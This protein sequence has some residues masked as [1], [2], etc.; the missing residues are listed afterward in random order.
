MLYDQT[1][2]G[3]YYLDCS[4][5]AF[6][7]IDLPL[8]DACGNMGYLHRN[9]LHVCLLLCKVVEEYRLLCFIQI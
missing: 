4:C 5:E 3:M 7:R 8:K 2:L 1:V 6:S 9:C